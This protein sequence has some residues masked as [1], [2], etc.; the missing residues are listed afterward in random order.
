MK[1][2]VG[3][4][5]PSHSASLATSLDRTAIAMPWHRPSG[6]GNGLNQ[7]SSLRCPGLLPEILLGFLILLMYCP[8]AHSGAPS[9]CQETSGVTHQPVL[10]RQQLLLPAGA[11]KPG[12]PRVPPPSAP[13][14]LMHSFLTPPR[15]VKNDNLRER[16]L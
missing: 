7:A 9:V 1:K 5:K 11:G 6:Q 13:G 2:H 12:L 8:A 16:G 3:S 15:H 14:N 10:G 4:C